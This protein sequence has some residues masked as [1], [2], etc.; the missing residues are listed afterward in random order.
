MPCARDTRGG[1][2]NTS[3][4][5]LPAFSGG[6]LGLANR[7]LAQRERLV[8]RAIPA[9]RIRRPGEDDRKGRAVG[10]GAVPTDQFRRS[11]LYNRSC[12][13]SKGAQGSRLRS[14]V[15]RWASSADFSCARVYIRACDARS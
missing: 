15:C 11:T 2:G 4:W 3:V 6:K 10:T 13:R 14:T 12:Q 1:L 7:A 8:L 9:V 5:A